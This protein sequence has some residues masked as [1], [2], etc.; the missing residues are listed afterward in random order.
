MR[1]Y[2]K[3]SKNSNVIPYNY[4]PLLTGVIHKWIGKE[5]REHGETSL[6]SFSWLRGTTTIKL[7]FNLS[8]YS[9]WF[10]SAYNA[11]LIKKMI[12][13]IQNDPEMFFGIRVNEITIQ[14]TPS[15]S[16]RERF[17]VANPVFIKKVINNKSKFYFY[18]EE[19]ADQLLTQSLKSKFKA[20]NL[21]SDGVLVAFDKEYHY[22]KI[23]G[24]MYNNI[25]NKGSICPI[26]VTGTPDQIAAAIE[27]EEPI[28]GMN[29]DG[30]PI[31]I[32]GMPSRPRP[33]QV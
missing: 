20:A 8:E 16:N 1:I 14:D 4:Q 22:S 9:Y 6:Y 21:N 13:G 19:G 7:G 3:I 28:N 18:N 32:G 26:I 15:F 23:K 30:D 10:F 2:L 11:D 27:N 5:N 17:N 31:Q 29:E 12:S 24:F 33:K 25:F